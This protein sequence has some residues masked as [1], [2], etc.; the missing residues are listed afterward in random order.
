MNKELQQKLI[1]KYKY[2]FVEK[3]RS[4]YVMTRH[5]ELFTEIADAKANN[6]E[7]KLAQ[8]LEEQKAL[9]S[10]HAIAF[11]FE[12]DDGWYDLLDKLME[13]IERVDINKQV[14]IHQIKE[15]LGGLRFYTSGTPIIIDVLNQGSIEM[16]KSTDGEKIDEYIHEAEN[17]SYKICEV[18]GKPGR[19]CTTGNWLKTVCTDHRKLKVW[20]SD[21]EIQEYHP[22]KYF[23]NE[24]EVIVDNTHTSIVSADFVLESDTWLYTLENGEIREE[25]VL[26]RKPRNKFYEG[27]FVTKDS[28][29]F[30]WIIEDK[31][32]TPADGWTYT[33][34][35]DNSV[36]GISSCVAKEEELIIVETGPNKHG[37]KEIKRIKVKPE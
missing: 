7:V 35:P 3:E 28:S 1:D 14:K 19:L 17:K 2:M 11:G 24:E 9:G 10:Y 6:D 33:L 29:G 18:C 8:L 32:F 12:C 16:G 25:S 13:N 31:I 26:K 4:H 36:L 23:C 21:T 34:A 5:S 22:I 27:W 20:H 30:E 37:Y 15:K